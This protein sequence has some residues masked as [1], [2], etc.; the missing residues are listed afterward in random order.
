MTSRLYV[1]WSRSERLLAPLAPF[2]AP[3][4]VGAVRR[5][6]LAPFV[7]WRRSAP[8]AGAVQQRTAPE[9]PLRESSVKNVGA[10]TGLSESRPTA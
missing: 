2:E 9:I 10:L 1:S 3:G 4:A 8:F 7:C 5:R 6:S